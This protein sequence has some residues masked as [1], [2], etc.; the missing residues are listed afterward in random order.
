M[1]C[2]RWTLPTDLSEEECWGEGVCRLVMEE[3]KNYLV[4]G[5]EEENHCVNFNSNKWNKF[6]IVVSKENL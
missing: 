3:T 6:F 5:I 4:S 2:F 1:L